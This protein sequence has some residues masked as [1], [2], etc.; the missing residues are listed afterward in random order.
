MGR[1][2]SRLCRVRPA[3]E[4]L[5]LA[6]TLTTTVIGN[7]TLKPLKSRA[8]AALF[9]MAA[10]LFLV[11]LCIFIYQDVLAPF[12]Y[13]PQ[14]G[15]LGLFLSG[16]IVILF[17]TGMLRMVG[18]F[19]SYAHEQD[20][21][22]RFVERVRENASNPL[23]KLDTQALIVGRVN[24][25]QTLYD[26]SGEI[27]QSALAAV[28]SAGEAA[29]FTLV[30]FVH[31]ILI[32]AG[33]FGTAVSLSVAL[34][35]VA[36]LLES[37]ESLKQ[38]GTVIGGM[39]TA[40]D[41]TMIAILCYAIYSYFHLRLQDTRTQLLANIEHVTTLHV[42]PHFRSTEGAI[43]NDI[44]GLTR[45]LRQ[46]A[47]AISKIQ[48]RFLHAGD[49][50]QLAVDDLQA[51]IIRVGNTVAKGVDSGSEDLRIIRESIREGF[52][53]EEAAPARPVPPPAPS[54]PTTAPTTRGGRL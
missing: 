28:M 32:M 12:F 7:K 48:D 23:H 10:L 18:L 11:G 15:R 54:V 35:G 22:E 16:G 50:L 27:N 6:R 38:M 4:G 33:V 3:D 9:L 47:E 13:S 20:V 37:P 17:L 8:Y 24:A 26:Q 29:R 19:L 2:Q 5:R 42:M 36:G 14:T 21:L 30:R 49:R 53:L 45:D 46:A 34:V 43:L 51:Q 31:N 25:L 44:S 39:S 1:N 41:T 40:L 52:R